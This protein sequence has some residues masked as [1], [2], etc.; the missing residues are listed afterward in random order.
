MVIIVPPVV[1][2]GAKLTAEVSDADHVAVPITPCAIAGIWNTCMFESVMYAEYIGEN[3]TWSDLVSVHA[4]APASDVLVPPVG[5]EV[6]EHAPSAA[7]TAHAPNRS[8]DTI[9][10]PKMPRFI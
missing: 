5:D 6:L 10:I 1:G 2:S 4:T 8:P 9:P 7:A 3:N